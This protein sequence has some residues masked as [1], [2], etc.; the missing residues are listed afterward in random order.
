MVRY[1]QKNSQRGRGLEY[2][3]DW[4]DVD[5]MGGRVYSFHSGPLAGSLLPLPSLEPRAEA[6]SG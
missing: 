2:S 5:K 4:K 6:V 1:K 3:E